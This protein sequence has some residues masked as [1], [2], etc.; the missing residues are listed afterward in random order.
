M[1]A[2]EAAAGNLSLFRIRE[3]E[4]FNEG[5]QII[6]GGQAVIEA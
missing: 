5:R 6:V 4:L 2:L 3:N 1:R